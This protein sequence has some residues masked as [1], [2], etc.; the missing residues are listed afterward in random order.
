MLYIFGP[1][2][3]QLFIHLDGGL[4]ALYRVSLRRDSNLDNRVFWISAE[5]H[6]SH[7]GAAMGK[8]V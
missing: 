1:V 8:A 3:E 6:I 2:L 4:L 5:K 7:G